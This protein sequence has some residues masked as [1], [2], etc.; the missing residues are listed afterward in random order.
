M[1]AS[2]TIDTGTRSNVLLVPSEA[3][4]LGVRGTTVNLLTKQYG[5]T[6]VEH[7]R[8]KTGGSDGVYTEI[9]QGLHEGQTVVLAG[10]DEGKKRSHSVS[11]LGPTDR[12]KL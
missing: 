4:K 9:R 12:G 5:R 11:P 10:L 8:V 7:R 2:T 1:T 3:I 6:R